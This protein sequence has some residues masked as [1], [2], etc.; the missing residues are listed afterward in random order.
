MIRLSDYVI[1]RVA[2]EGVK[3][4]F[5]VSGGGG[6]FLIESLGQHK[7]LQYV[8]NHHEQAVAMA[9]DAYPRMTGNLGVALVTTGPA[10]TNVLTG[11]MCSWTDSVPLLVLSGQAKSTALI[12]NTG[13]RQRGFHEV[14]ITKI[15]ESVTKYAVT[16]RDPKSIGYHLDK[17]IFLAKT[18]R[19]GPVWVDIPVDIQ[20]TMIEPSQLI[21]FEPEREFPNSVVPQVQASEIAQLVEHLKRARRPVFLSGHGIRL[22]GQKDAF[23][24]LAELVHVP[25]VTSR[26]GLDLISYDHPLYAGFIGNYGQRAANFTVQNADLVISLGSRL[27]SLTVGYEPYL[28]AREATHVVVDIDEAQIKHCFIRI[29]QPIRADLRTF[30][31][32]LLSALENVPLPDYS[33]WQNQIHHWQELFPNVLP[34]MRAQQQYV[35]PYYFYEVLSEEMTAA[36]T[37][38]WDQGAAYHCA[39]VAFKTRKGQRAF[40]ADG[41]T[42]MGYGLPAAI[43]AC[44]ASG[45]K[46]LVCVHGDGGLQLNVQ[47][48]QTVWHHRLP[49]K[50]FVF[51]NQGYTSIKHTQT[52][53]FEGHLVGV[54]PASG[55]SCPD[56]LKLAAG[57]QLPAIRVENHDHLR[58]AIRQALDSEGP[59]VVEVV[60]HPMQPIEPRV[61]SE[62]LPDGRMVSKPLEDMFPYI[63]RELFLREMIV[64]PMA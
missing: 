55:L 28:F 54:D 27:S 10:A 25:V 46:R 20:G 26:N 11:L 63:E 30:I 5:M 3:H 61:K 12:D 32:Q 45:K 14:N 60:L 23:L 57:Y 19:P 47:E 33:P 51:N 1:N 42:P 44:F 22:A 50:L 39:A 24:R 40:S 2:R 18:G 52:Q 7:D 35:N 36:D 16:V 56:T 13:L 17:A 64:K 9:A 53:Y 29:D 58:Q 59:F 4:V 49:I 31:P 21:P 6:M 37:L 62:R 38:I 41:F 43:G 48:L 8:C 34:A 15:V